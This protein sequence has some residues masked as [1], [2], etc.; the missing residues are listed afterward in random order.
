MYSREKAAANSNSQI[1]PL[2]SNSNSFTAGLNASGALRSFGKPSFL[3]GAYSKRNNAKTKSPQSQHNKQLE[4]PRFVGLTF[5][6]EETISYLDS[7]FLEFK[8]TGRIALK[9]IR[10]YNGNSVILQIDIFTWMMIP[11]IPADLTAGKAICERLSVC[12]S[13]YIHSLQQYSIPVE[14]YMHELM[15]A[16]LISAQNFHVLYQLLQYRVPTDSERLAK[17]LLEASGSFSPFL[18]ISLDM[19]HRLGLHAYCVDALLMKDELLLALKTLQKHPHCLCKVSSPINDAGITSRSLF[20]CALRIGSRDRAC[21]S[22][23]VLHSFFM[24]VDPQVITVVSTDEEPK[25]SL[26]KDCK[27]VEI[28][29]EISEIKEWPAIRRVFGFP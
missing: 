10:C 2:A 9:D 12:L 4:S 3:F 8:E 29:P 1:V 13:E 22:F 26:A 6:D 17:I 21:I 14:K 15:C 7:V 24:A 5:D 11:S 20:E 27:D 16:L 23:S 18:Q 25:S 28:P 19:F